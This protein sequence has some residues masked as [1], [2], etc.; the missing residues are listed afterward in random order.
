MKVIVTSVWGEMCTSSAWERENWDIQTSHKY[1]I[2][3]EQGNFYFFLLFFFL[4]TRTVGHQIQFLVKKNSW[5]RSHHWRLKVCSK[6]IVQMQVNQGLLNTVTW[7]AL[8][9]FV[10]QKLGGKECVYA[11]HFSCHLSLK[12]NY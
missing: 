12:I 1:Y 2:G 6:E 7:E 8:K 9:F 10:R 5:N 3:R 11:C 4:N